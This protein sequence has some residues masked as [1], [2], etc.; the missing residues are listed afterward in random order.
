MKRISVIIMTLLLLS[1][2]DVYKA[3]QGN[4]AVVEFLNKNL[5]SWLAEESEIL[6]KYNSLVTADDFSSKELWKELNQNLIP[7]TIRLRDR[8]EKSK[9]S[10]SGSEKIKKLYLEKLDAHL[11]KGFDL[12][13]EGLKNKK[14]A[15]AEEMIN[16]GRS[17]LRT[18]SQMNQ[19][20]EVRIKKMLREFYIKNIKD[21]NKKNK[22]D[23]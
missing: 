20:M 17:H 13:Q 11:L 4:R 5:N 18:V 2:C 1:S 3:F 22:A 8:I 12:I 10:G 7:A 16:Q 9:V 6:K 14:S 23:S 19:E 21:S 15:K